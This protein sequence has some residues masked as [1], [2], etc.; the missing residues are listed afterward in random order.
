MNSNI[1]FMRLIDTMAQ[2]LAQK[3]NDIAELVQEIEAL[4]SKLAKYESKEFFEMVGTSSIGD[5]TF[6]VYEKFVPEFV[7]DEEIAMANL[8][9]PKF[10]IS[11]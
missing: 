8:I 5:H 9:A 6:N 7:T 10:D 1:D 2:I 3:N 11:E 4:E